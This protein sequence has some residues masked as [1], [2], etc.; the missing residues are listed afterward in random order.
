MIYKK[1]INC[2][3]SNL[4]CRYQRLD[5]TNTVRVEYSRGTK[6][7][8]PYVINQLVDLMDL[9]KR[10]QYLEENIFAPLKK[11]KLYG[12]LQRFSG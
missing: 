9:I 12:I 2:K 3:E 11:Y 1:I 8:D 4:Q 6:L 5:S 10:T 7:Y